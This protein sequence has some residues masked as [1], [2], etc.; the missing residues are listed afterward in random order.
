VTNGVE[1]L[2]ADHSDDQ[3]RQPAPIGKSKKTKTE[4]ERLPW[5]DQ[6]RGAR[7]P[8]LR[9]LVVTIRDALDNHEKTNGDCRRARRP[10]DQRRYEIAVETV[11]A[12]LAHSALFNAT[13]KRLA[14]LTGNK[15]R[16]FTRY[17]NDALGKPLRRLL[18]GFEALGLVRWRWSLQRGVASSVAPQN[19]L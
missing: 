5:F 14:I 9:S 7:G 16:G 1:T 11:L 2:T 19:T 17:E 18:G 4:P 8:A 6:W 12:N 3:P 10:D 15:S 13:D